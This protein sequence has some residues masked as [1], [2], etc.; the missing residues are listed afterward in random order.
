MRTLNID[1]ET[2]SSID[3]KASGVYRYVEAPDFTILMIAYSFD[4]GPVEIITENY[5]KLLPDLLNGNVI[6][7][8]FNANFERTCLAK[9]FGKEMPASQ[10]ECTMVKGA[11][12]GLPFSLDAVAKALKLEQKKD[13]A[14]KFLIKYFSAPCKPTIIN[15]GRTRNLPEHAP[16]KWEAF[17]QYCIQDVTVEKNIR[18][19]LQAFETTP[20]E[21][22]CWILDQKINDRGVMVDGLL[23]KNAIRFDRKKSEELIQ[24]AVEITKLENPNSLPQLK[25]WL[26]EQTDGEIT[27]LT[28][29]DTPKILANTDNETVKK[30]I[31]IR[32][33]LGRTSVKKYMAM[34]LSRCDDG[35]VRGIHQFYGAARTGRWAGRKV[36]PQNMAKNH[37]KHLA[38]ARQILKS[39]EYE[40]FELMFGDIPD[41]L[42]QLVRT[43]ITA[44]R[45]SELDVSDFSAIEARVI[46][47]L[48]NEKWRLDVFATHGKIYEASASE[49]FKV[50]L[51]SISYKDSNGKTVEGPNYSL[52]AKGKVAELALGYQGAANALIKMG[53]LEMGLTEEELPI[54]VRKW[55]R[56]NPA[57][58]K[59][60]YDL[61]SAVRKA[62]STKRLVCF[63]KGIRIFVE[64][65]MLFIELP[66]KRRLAYPSPAIK[67]NRYGSSV[68]TY[69]SM[70]SNARIWGEE[71]TYGGKLTENI[72]QAIARDCLVEAMLRADKKGLNIIM[73]V[74]DEIV[75]E[76]EEGSIS[77]EE[78]NKMMSEPIDWAP[79]LPLK[80]AGFKNKYYKKD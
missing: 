67:E 12:L 57:I 55:R 60:W 41:T 72:T 76:E 36:Q 77:I 21:R 64:R 44:K 42:S 68:I 79:G 54:L 43:A 10:W 80:A 49:M 46:A 13:S 34:A 16:E 65:N 7:T 33:E 69:K 39:D 56:A 35:R 50:P 58:V 47:W 25:K 70:G 32:Q 2:Y 30:V 59:L 6:K 1:I 45:G 15:K 3:L 9:Y 22:E 29:K 48:A 61:E 31:K 4:D 28:K 52:R 37:M 38:E 24:K 26:N 17:K 71:D 78:V 74:H 11:I 51:E 27:T 23:I 18:K 5:D 19:K 8:A 63:N 62:I 14:G 40:L 75:F 66:S 73:H 20:T 53:A